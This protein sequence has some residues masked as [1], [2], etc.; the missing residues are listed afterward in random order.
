MDLKKHTMNQIHDFTRTSPILF[1]LGFALLA[2]L[3]NLK[4]SSLFF[5][6]FPANTWMNILNEV[7]CILWPAALAVFFGFRFIFR[8]RGI[9]ATFG[10]AL[11]MFLLFGY[12]LFSQLKMTC[13]NPDTQW[14]SALEIFWGILFLIGVGFREEVLYRGVITN[15]IARKYGNSTKGL[16]ITA[17][18]AGAMFGA[19]HML[20]VFQNVSFTGALVQ[21]IGAF[22]SGVFL[23]AVYL[24]GGSIWGMALL[25]TLIDAPPLVKIL[26]TNTAVEDLS[27]LVSS[28]G[29]GLVQIIFLVFELLLAAFLLRKSKRQ[30]IIS[31]IQQLNSSEAATI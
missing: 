17:L 7:L 5:L 21:S 9:R 13:T 29:L 10:A 8:R 22:I 15:A 24:R 18:S 2:G 27:G 30:K 14:K 1:S 16:W 25:H 6:L 26:F 28:Y 12:M 23:C 19:V 11:P 4:F 20:N 3:I 31:R